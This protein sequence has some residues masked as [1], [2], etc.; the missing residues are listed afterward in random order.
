MEKPYTNN[1]CLASNCDTTH[2]SSRYGTAFLSIEQFGRK[3]GNPHEQNFSEEGID[4]AGKVHA[5]WYITTPR[6]VGAVRDYWWNPSDQLSIAAPNKWVYLWVKG[7]LRVHG[8]RCST[9]NGK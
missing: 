5:I 3:F 7:W 8:V 6:G 4:G 9:G 1:V 2:G